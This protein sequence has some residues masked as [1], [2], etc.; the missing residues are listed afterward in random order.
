MQ[1]TQADTPTLYEIMGGAERLRA[2]VDRFYDLMQ[3][4][5]EF[6]NIHVMHPVPNDSSRDKLFMFLS[7]WM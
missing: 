3:L 4:E 6:A 2:L 5:S 1:D 7:G